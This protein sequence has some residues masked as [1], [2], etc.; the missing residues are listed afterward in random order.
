MAPT[1]QFVRDGLAFNVTEAGPADGEP[2]LLL[3]GF[4]QHADSWNALVPLLTGAGYRTLAVDQRGYSPGARPTG[5]RA[6][7]ITELVADAAAAIGHFS[8]GS[9]RMHVVGHDWGAAVAWALAAAHPEKVA[10][11]TALSVPH[12]GAFLRSMA[13]TRQGL[14]SWYMLFFQLP[15]LPER[16]VRRQFVRILVASGQAAG[17][18]H[19]DAEAFAA[20]GA[21][22][23]ALNWYRAMPFLDPRRAGDPVTV[24]TLF[25]WSDADRFVDRRSA[26]ACARFVSGPYQFETLPGVS[27]WIPDLAPAE[28]AAVLLPH[29]GRHPAV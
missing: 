22:T 29:L 26:E 25:V 7:R 18:A 23:A 24:P 5:R 27:H 14:R 28:T 2:V 15:L 19:R 3:H 13:T 16:V 4:P 11:L 20:P 8:T 17:H 10:S 1:T 9:G 6:Y 21:L 12:V